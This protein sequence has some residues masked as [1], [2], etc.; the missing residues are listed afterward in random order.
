[1]FVRGQHTVQP[2]CIRHMGVRLNPAPYT[3]SLDD[4]VLSTLLRKDLSQCMFALSEAA[5]HSMFDERSLH[6]CPWVFLS[7][8]IQPVRSQRSSH[9]ETDYVM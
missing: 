3:L 5:N 4:H 1:M 6:Q 9:G 7:L 8:R 2:I